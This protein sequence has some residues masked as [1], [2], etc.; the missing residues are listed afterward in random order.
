MVL[1][2]PR[3]TIPRKALPLPKTKRNSITAL[4]IL[5]PKASK[6]GIKPIRNENPNNNKIT[7]MGKTKLTVAVRKSDSIKLSATFISDYRR[8]KNMR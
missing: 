4:L 2:Q 1:V 8:I 5:S 7:V 6:L 3:V